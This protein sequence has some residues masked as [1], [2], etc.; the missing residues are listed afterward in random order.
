MTGEPVKA[1]IRFSNGAGA[2]APDFDQ[3]GRG[4]AIKL[5]LPDG[6][7]T[8]MVGLNLP[9]FFVRTPED[10]IEFTRSRKPDPETGK[11]DM[12]KIGAWVGAHPEAQV[13]LQAAVTTEPPD[14]YATV[15]YNG[16]HSF[17]WSNADGEARYVRYRWE[18]E[19]G[20]REL[21]E[22]EARARG[23]DY[24]REDIVGRAGAAFRLSVALAEEDDAVDDPTVPWPEE[25]ERVEVG[26]LELAGP[27]E[28][29]E[30]DGDVLVFDPMRLIDGI[31]PSDDQILRFR[32][33]AYAVSVERRSG[34]PSPFR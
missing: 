4:I 21:S 19:E 20:R 7:R 33:L 29:R 9:C 5:Y 2:A 25:R 17:R 26:R 31:D 3:D 14:S 8:D 24:L 13:A 15:A 28:E 18:P 16:I 32:P 10:F 34:H 23:R 27:D 30:R 1:T 11:P 22:E 6:S 12:E